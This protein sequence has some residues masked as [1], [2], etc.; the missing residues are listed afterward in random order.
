M[1]SLSLPL[2]DSGRPVSPAVSPHTYSWSGSECP[3]FSSPESQA[4]ASCRLHKRSTALEPRRG[5]AGS[6]WSPPADS[7]SK[8]KGNRAPSSDW[9]WQRPPKLM[10]G[11]GW[12]RHQP[13]VKLKLGC[14]EVLGSLWWRHSLSGSNSGCS[15]SPQPVPPLPFS[16]R[17]GLFVVLIGIKLGFI[18]K[19]KKN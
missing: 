5:A 9:R 17:S 4:S 1:V 12:R 7:C 18:K 15:P 19:K 13:C 14:P 8:T 16:V 2:P 6:P 3:T 10:L 11:K